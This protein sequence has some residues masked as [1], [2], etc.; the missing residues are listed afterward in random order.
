MAGSSLGMF[1]VVAVATVAL[2][3]SAR[4]VGVVSA[5]LIAVTPARSVVYFGTPLSATG[6]LNTIVMTAAA[7][8]TLTMPIGEVGCGRLTP[9]L[10]RAARFLIVREIALGMGT[11]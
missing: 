1:N 3:V 10:R 2:N 4:V 6:W 11:P 9:F 5:A 8:V 7:L